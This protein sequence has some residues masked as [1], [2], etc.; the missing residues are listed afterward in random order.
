MPASRRRRFGYLRQLPSKR[1]QAS[2][3][4]P[5]GRRH[6]APDTFDRRRDAEQWL[7]VVEA[8]MLRGEWIN[9]VD[10]AVT[11]DEYASRWIAERPGL[12]PRTIDLYRWL[13]GK[14]IGPHLGRV[15]LGE[16]DPARVR[17][18]RAEAPRGRCVGDDDRE[19]LPPLARGPHDGGR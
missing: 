9:P 8:Q 4:D 12:R 7:S 6:F 19:G 10:Q 3:T 16:I 5:D 17:A 1:W 15:A 13:F 2:Y 18:W 11:L 14:H